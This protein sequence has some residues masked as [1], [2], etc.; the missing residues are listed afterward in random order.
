MIGYAF[1]P[2]FLS[3]VASTLLHLFGRTLFPGL[4]PFGVEVIQISIE[5]GGLLWGIRGVL[6]FY[7]IQ[8]THQVQAPYALWIIVAV[9]IIVIL[10]NVLSLFL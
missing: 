6:A 9:N 7:G 3:I 4:N 1:F 2:Y 10:Y 8:R 5:E